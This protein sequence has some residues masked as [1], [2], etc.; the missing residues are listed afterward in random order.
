MNIIARDYL[1]N[2]GPPKNKQPFIAKENKRNIIRARI[3][4]KLAH[5]LLN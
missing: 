3:D 5:H 4:S 2:E 1:N